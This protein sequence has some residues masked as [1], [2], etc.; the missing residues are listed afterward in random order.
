MLAP[1]SLFLYFLQREQRWQ[2]SSKGVAFCIIFRQSRKGK[3]RNLQEI[4]LLSSFFFLLVLPAWVCHC[5]FHSSA[6]RP[7]PTPPYPWLFLGIPK[8]MG[9]WI[10]LLA[11]WPGIL[12]TPLGKGA[13]FLQCC[14]LIQKQE[15]HDVDPGKAFLDL[16][17]LYCK[18]VQDSYF[19]PI[20]TVTN[21]NMHDPMVLSQ[22]T[23]FLV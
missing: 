19:L 12:I 15:L 13:H 14:V 18:W 17:T 6:G 10:V 3:V 5:D 23:P 9:F 4:E 20:L 2:S 11:E 22:S 21:S 16:E 8:S 1:A 7:P